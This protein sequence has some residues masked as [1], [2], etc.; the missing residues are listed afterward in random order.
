MKEAAADI[1][2]AAALR[3]GDGSIYIRPGMGYNFTIRA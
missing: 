3:R 1:T 2:P